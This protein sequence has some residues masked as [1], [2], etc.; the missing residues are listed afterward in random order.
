M[1]SRETAQQGLALLKQAIL[2]EL[3]ANPSGLSNADIVNRLELQSDFEGENK[4]YLSWSILG[5]LVGEGKV[6]HAGERQKKR[7]FLA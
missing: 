4:N 6:K 1:D 2:S 5:L 7:Y 3:A